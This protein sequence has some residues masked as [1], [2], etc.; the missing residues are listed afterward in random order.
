MRGEDIIDAR[1]RESTGVTALVALRI[2]PMQVPHTVPMPAISYQT[3]VPGFLHTLRQTLGLARPQIQVDC[4]ADTYQVAKD[5]AAQVR[6]SLDGFSDAVLIL[7]ERPLLDPEVQ[8]HRVSQ[9]Y[10]VWSDDQ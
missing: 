3:V 1:L 6:Q 7:D 2:Y 4:W 8:R 10:A 9:D 5:V